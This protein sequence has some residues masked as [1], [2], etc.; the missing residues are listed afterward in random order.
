MLLASPVRADILPQGYKWIGHEM[1]IM[2]LKDYPGYVFYAYPRHTD[3]ERAPAQAEPGK[4]ASLSG[5]PLAT[6]HMHLYAVPKELFDQAKG[7][8]QPSWFDGKTSS[9]LRS[10]EHV[11]VRRSAKRTDPT[12]RLVTQFEVA[13]T[14]GKLSYR[15]VGEKH[16]DRDNK[17]VTPD[18]T[19]DEGL[20]A[21]AGEM[22]TN[23]KFGYYVGIP[24]A[25]AVLLGVTLVLRRRKPV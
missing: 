17:E 14:D 9:V 24:T 19:E 25:A 21:S 10:T 22:T 16:V 13:I 4:T 11:G 3:F 1:E 7:K 12:E 20:T 23:Q 5:N 2:N 6:G 18:S 8:P 15:Q